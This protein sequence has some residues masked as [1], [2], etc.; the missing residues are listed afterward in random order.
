ML[1]ETIATAGD[2]ASLIALQQPARPTPQAP[3]AALLHEGRPRDMMGGP[4]GHAPINVP[5]RQT[6]RNGVSATHEGPG[7]FETW[8]KDQAIKDGKSSGHFELFESQRSQGW[9]PYFDRIWRNALGNLSVRALKGMRYAWNKWREH[10]M[11]CRIYWRTTSTEDLAHEAKILAVCGPTRPLF[12]SQINERKNSR[13]WS[14]Y[15]TCNVREGH[16]A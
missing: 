5:P 7:H 8:M 2:Q 11:D 3:P 9:A 12:R 4:R 14:A 15:S 6:R 10:T 13:G 16:E 1:H